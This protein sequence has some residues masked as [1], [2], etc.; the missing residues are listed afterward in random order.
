MHSMRT[1]DEARR[2]IEGGQP[3][4]LAGDEALL[5]A[6]P[7]GDWIGGT[8]PYF[9]TAQGGKRLLGRDRAVG[10]AGAPRLRRERARL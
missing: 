8:I 9:M 7:L 1:V 6:L 5:Q 10:L 3:L 4:L 2:L